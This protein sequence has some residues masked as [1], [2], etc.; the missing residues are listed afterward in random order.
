MAY[1]KHTHGRGQLAQKLRRQR[2][3]QRDE[4]RA[5]ADQGHLLGKVH[6]NN[7]GKALC[8]NKV[9]FLS[10]VSRD[11]FE[12]MNLAGRCGTCEILSGLRPGASETDTLSEEQKNLLREIYEKSNGAADKWC[13]TMYL[14][15]D[16][17]RPSSTSMYRSLRRLERRGDI[18]KRLNE[19]KRAEVQLTSR[20]HVLDSGRI[21][22]G[23]R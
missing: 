23:S 11:E 1:L 16:N 13:L 10:L 20:V 2:A 14:C 18:E 21:V 19:Q 4:K 12:K 5:V 17:Y 7:G 8:R 3:R 6:I 22:I 15:S 9:E